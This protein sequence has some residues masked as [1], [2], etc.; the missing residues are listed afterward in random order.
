MFFRIEQMFGTLILDPLPEEYFW[1]VRLAEL[2]AKTYPIQDDA[3]R[4]NWN[5][6]KSQRL[7]Y[8]ILEKPLLRFYL[9]IRSYQ[10]K[11]CLQHVSLITRLVIISFSVG[12]RSHRHGLEQG[13]NG[14][15][16][17]WDSRRNGSLQFGAVFSPVFCEKTSFVM[18]RWKD[19]RNLLCEL[20]DVV[21]FLI[22]CLEGEWERGWFGFSPGWSERRTAELPC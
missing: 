11:L 10:F 8:T 17:W 21:A 6:L 5:I 18:L 19:S 13:K 3:C 7:S 16:F 20:I 14:F 1:V 4:M 15:G 12:F 2:R 22:F 9:S